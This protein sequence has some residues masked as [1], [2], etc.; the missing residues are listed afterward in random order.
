MGFGPAVSGPGSGNREVT[1]QASHL[2]LVDLKV[3]DAAL[4][5]LGAPRHARAVGAAAETVS[6]VV[7][8][9]LAPKPTLL[10]GLGCSNN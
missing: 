3:V 4:R 5:A 10:D 6:A 9:A 2:L 8:T 1:R 7:L